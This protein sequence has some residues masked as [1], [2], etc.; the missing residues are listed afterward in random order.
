MPKFSRADLKREILRI[1]LEGHEFID[2]GSDEHPGGQHYYLMPD[3][4]RITADELAR[5]ELD[6]IP[7]MPGRPETVPWDE[8]HLRVLARLA[9][10]IPARLQ[11]VKRRQVVVKWIGEEIAAM[12]FEVPG[13]TI[14]GRHATYIET[15]MGQAGERWAS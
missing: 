2:L 11:Q 10:G 3:G 13:R 4:T 1:K 5:M 14:V 8:V 15:L 7:E 12:Y 6:V 9:N